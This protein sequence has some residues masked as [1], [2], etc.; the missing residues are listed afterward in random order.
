MSSNDELPADSVKCPS[1]GAPNQINSASWDKI[2]YIPT[3]CVQCSE[4]FWS[5]ITTETEITIVN[6]IPVFKVQV[7]ELNEGTFVFII[8]RDHVKHLEPG[9][10]MKRDHKHYKI[11]FNDGMQLWVPSCWV[12]Q[13][14]KEML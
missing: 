6:R 1:C 11:K 7:P 5:P 9:Q 8:Q 10:I 4:L 12:E 2:G 3:L 13:I 14:P